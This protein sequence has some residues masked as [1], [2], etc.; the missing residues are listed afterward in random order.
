LSRARRRGRADL[1]LALAAGLGGA[2]LALTGATEVADD[3]VY[4]RA[5]ALMPAP[6]AGSV[7]V[8]AIDDPSFREIG[9]GWPW[10][11]AEHAALVE[12]L[13]AG[14]ARAIGLDIIFTDPSDP[15]QDTALAAALG[16]DVVLAADRE[17]EA[18]PHG[19]VVRA[20]DP[21][22]MLLATGATAAQIGL[23]VD[24]D[25]AIRRLPTDPAAL[26]L[27]MSGT[28]PPPGAR[29]RFAPGI[30]PQVSWYQAR[31]A[32]D[33]LPPGIFRDRIVLVGMDLRSSPLT[34]AETFR[35]PLTARGDGLMPGVEIHAQALRSLLA[36]DWIVPVP[37]LA[38]ALLALLLGAVAA[39][40]LAG[41]SAAETAAATAGLTLLP[42]GLAAVL[43][44]SGAWLPPVAPMLAA[45]AGGVG[46][47][48]LDLT[49]ERRDRAE[50]T[51]IFGQ[52]L[53]PDVVRRLAEAPEAVKLGG[54][55]RVITVMFCDLRGFTTLSER[56]T[57]DPETLVSVLN[58]ALTVIGDAV[59]AH[60]GMIDKFIGD[61]VMGIWNAP[62][63]D[64]DHAR[65]A[66]A[67]ARDAV[68]GIA[69]LSAALE[70]EG[71]PVRLAC[72]AGINTGEATVGNLGSEKRFDYTAVGDV[73]NV[74]ARLETLTKDLGTP[75]LIAEATAA[76]A[77]GE[78]LVEREAVEIRGRSARLRVFTP[79]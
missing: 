16:P 6:A 52:Y 57:N 25:G 66:I 43:L 20:V 67:A 8:V 30:V 4:D 51:R 13:R 26:T 68:A 56:L 54:E 5:L 79:A 69:A 53:A 35:T 33:F 15:Q 11:R 45:L 49:R 41:R 29:I 21:M 61:C 14:G 24:P 47:A 60:R 37:V 63:D 22:P 28:E 65:H 18:T 3:A 38:P 46:R 72:G 36:R 42:A 1:A 62:A 17:A 32:G 77:P 40:A 23:P 78:P 55:R 39:L 50:I 71:L 73:V 76:H 31:R 19:L 27:R 74:A 34:A 64:P 10:P 7:M 48:G 12:T 2:A 59:L 58:R 75:I 9:R 70:A 44:A